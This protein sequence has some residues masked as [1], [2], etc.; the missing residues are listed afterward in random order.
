MAPCPHSEALCLPLSAQARLR[1]PTPPAQTRGATS[2]F[3]HHTS[4]L[5]GGPP[6]QS[7]LD[8]DALLANVT[9]DRPTAFS[10]MDSRENWSP[11]QQVSG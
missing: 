8:G 10:P 9:G 5:A 4:T 7:W 1:L 11:P 3:N 6:P 2:L